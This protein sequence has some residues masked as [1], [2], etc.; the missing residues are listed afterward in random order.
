[1]LLASSLCLRHTS[2]DTSFSGAH[3]AWRH[4]PSPNMSHHTA[5]HTSGGSPEPE[6]EEEVGREL[7]LAKSPVPSPTT[8]SE[9]S[10]H[11]KMTSRSS[12]LSIPLRRSS[13]FNPISPPSHSSSSRPPLSQKFWVCFARHASL[14]GGRLVRCSSPSKTAQILLLCTLSNG[15]TVALTLSSL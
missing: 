12:S 4:H 14:T 11:L 5:H 15:T 1:M 7:L 6:G 3:S 2:N 10:L 13:S 8:L 9:K